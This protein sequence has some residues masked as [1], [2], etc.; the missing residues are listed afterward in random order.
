M[1]LASPEK[2]VI[3]AALRDYRS[4]KTTKTAKTAKT[5]G[6]PVYM[7]GMVE[8]SKGLSKVRKVL[9][10]CCSPSSL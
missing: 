4:N 6:V 2:A 8:G 1:G 9:Y 5:A 10:K 7:W 3:I